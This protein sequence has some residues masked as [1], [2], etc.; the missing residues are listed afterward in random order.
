MSEHH[1][2][3]GG[4]ATANPGNR[5]DASGGAAWWPSGMNAVSAAE[6]QQQQQQQQAQ[7]QQQN[8]HQHLMN[9]QQQ[10]N[11]QQQQQAQQQQQQQHHQQQQHQQ[12]QD[13]VR[14]TAAG[15]Q[16]LFSYKMASSF[17][18]PATTGTQSSPVSTSTPVGSCMRGGYD[19]RLGNAPGSG[20]GGVPGTPSAPPPGVQWWYPGGVMDAAAQN[21]LHQQLQSQQQQQ[22]HLSPITTQT[23]TPPVMSPHQIQQLPQQNNLQQNNAQGLQRDNMPRGKDSK[24]RGRMT[25][26]AFFVQT[27]R[28]EHKKKHPEEKIIFR[29]FSKK[30]ATRWKNCYVFWSC[31]TLFSKKPVLNRYKYGISTVEECYSGILVLSSEIALSIIAGMREVQLLA[32][33]AHFEEIAVGM[34]DAQYAGHTPHPFF[35]NFSC[36]FLLHAS[37]TVTTVNVP[38]N[39]YCS[40]SYYCLLDSPNWEP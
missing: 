40:A 3:A 22:Q 18:N 9:Q 10:L 19:F 7:Q 26:Y 32:F 36:R 1:R 28:Q 11:Q 5:E 37:I 4:W 14:S 23:S 20:G 29:E 27:C 33:F 12:Q 31:P 34:A 2:V 13:I 17:Q 35:A 39:S 6:Q 15:T 21:N 25:A 30:C 16:Q 8:L 24:P 38:E